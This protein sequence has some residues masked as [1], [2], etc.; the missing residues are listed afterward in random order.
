MKPIFSLLLVLPFFACVHAQTQY[1]VTYNYTTGEVKR[2]V[3]D[4]EARQYQDYKRKSIKR[5]S[6]LEVK[7]VGINPLAADVVPELKEN[8]L[9]ATNGTSKLT[10]GNVISSFSQNALGQG[11]NFEGQNLFNSLLGES[12]ARKSMEMEGA[13]DEFGAMDFEESSVYEDAYYQI[14][15]RM[16]RLSSAYAQVESIRTQLTARILNPISTKESIKEALKSA[17]LLPLDEIYYEDG[18]G[19]GDNPITYLT[20]LEQYIRDMSDE[21]KPSLRAIASGAEPGSELASLRIREVEAVSS[22]LRKNNTLA[23]DEL[24]KIKKL[25]IEL[26]ATNFEHSNSYPVNSDRLDLS[27]QVIESDL[28]ES[29]DNDDTKTLFKTMNFRFDAVGGWRVNTGVALTLNNFGASSKEYF[30]DNGLIGQADDNY[31]TPNL[32]TLVSFYPELGKGLNLGGTFGVSVPISSGEQN[33]SG[34]NFLLGGSLLLGRQ[35][36]I[37]LSGG[38]AYGPVDK[39][40]NGLQAGDAAPS[41]DPDDFTRRV[42]DIGYFFGVS[43]T[44][45]NIN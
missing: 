31:F 26:E 35:N 36:M 9:Y 12:G 7:V 38:L 18:M 44:L 29:L 11:L 32:S 33:I 3:Y 37:A 14:N 19:I 34:I 1:R 13:D 21:I 30:V 6:V 8:N 2:E 5:G 4:E 17:Q 40:T 24:Q 39:L 43:F 23:I 10:I 28:A 22:D 16:R 15:Q 45:A 20:K 42:Y 25:L 27:L 41:G